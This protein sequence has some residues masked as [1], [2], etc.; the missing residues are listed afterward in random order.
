MTLNENH[1]VTP[2]TLIK[3]FHYFGE[4]ASKEATNTQKKT[5]PGL[6]W[7]CCAS[8]LATIRNKGH[9]VMN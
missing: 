4:N 1:D 5:F 6:F 8:L 9:R 2:H 7:E 3:T